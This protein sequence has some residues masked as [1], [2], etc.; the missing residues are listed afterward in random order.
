MIER[1]CCQCKGFRLSESRWI[2]RVGGFCR[3]KQFFLKNP[4]NVMLFCPGPE[5]RYKR[6]RCR[7]ESG[8]FLRK[9]C[10]DWAANC[11][12][13]DPVKFV[14]IRKKKFGGQNEK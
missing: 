11:E 8:D 3:I 14:K 5:S 4:V 1:V 10:E 12:K 13:F 6:G 9:L 7:L 2:K